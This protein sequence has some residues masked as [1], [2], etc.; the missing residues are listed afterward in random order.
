MSNNKC[1]KVYDTYDEAW[2]LWH[3][4]FFINKR[5]STLEKTISFIKPLFTGLSCECRTPQKIKQ[6]SVSETNI[7]VSVDVL[8][9]IRKPWS[10]MGGWTLHKLKN[11]PRL[12]KWTALTSVLGN[13]TELL[14]SSEKCAVVRRSRTVQWKT[15][16]MHIAHGQKKHKEEIHKYIFQKTCSP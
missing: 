2:H 16:Y 11:S 7:Q 13:S 12:C 1:K 14:T 6:W 3:L 10:V 15:N 5:V 8:W 4:T 9:A